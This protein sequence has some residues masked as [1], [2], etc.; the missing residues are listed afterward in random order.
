MRKVFRTHIILVTGGRLFALSGLLV[1]V[2]LIYTSITELIKNR[3]LEWAFYLLLLSIAAVFCAKHFYPFF[4]PKFF[5]KIIVTDDKVTFRCLGMIPRTFKIEE[6]KYTR[7]KVFDEGNVVKTDLYNTGFLYIL[8]SKTPIPEKT[9]DKY[10]CTKDLIIFP[11]SN[12]LCKCLYETL[13]EPQNLVFEYKTRIYE[14]YLK[15]KKRKKEQR[16]E[17]R[18][19]KREKMRAERL[20]PDK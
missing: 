14:S 17:K 1:E 2:W 9:V 7:L 5:G 12:K 15:R 13:Q 16:R 11:F 10:K 18:R 20:K 4:W 8:L 6:I 3:T 19:E